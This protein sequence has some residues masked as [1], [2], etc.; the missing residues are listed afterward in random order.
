MFVLRSVFTCVRAELWS[1]CSGQR[2][3]EWKTLGG[4]TRRWG[5]VTLSLISLH[6]LFPVFTGQ[7]SSLMTE[8]CQ[9]KSFSVSPSWAEGESADLES[10][11]DDTI[12]ETTRRRRTYPRQILPHVVH[13]LKAERKL[14]VG[15]GV[16]LSERS[17]ELSDVR[18]QSPELENQL[19]IDIPR[20]CMLLLTLERLFVQILFLLLSVARVQI[21]QNSTLHFTGPWMIHMTSVKPIR[22]MVPTDMWGTHTQRERETSGIIR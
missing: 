18:L 13:S 15:V 14:M 12:V 20:R 8:V 5:W 3:G 17:C 10:L 9:M 11:L 1:C 22:W 4:G 16:G 19:L 7:I 6:N 21:A 2:V